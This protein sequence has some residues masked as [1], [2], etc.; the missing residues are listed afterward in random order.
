VYRIGGYELGG[1]RCGFVESAG[2]WQFEGTAEMRKVIW[3][4]KCLSNCNV[5]PAKEV[6]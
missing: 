6:S 1:M 2:I 3:L 5:H 4:R